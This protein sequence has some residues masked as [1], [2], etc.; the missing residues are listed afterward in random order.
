MTDQNEQQPLKS[1][2]ERI[3][4]CYINCSYINATLQRCLDI[5]ERDSILDEI[6]S[7][8]LAARTLVSIDLNSYLY[9][10]VRVNLNF[11]DFDINEK[12]NSRMNDFNSKID[13]NLYDIIHKA[14]RATYFIKADYTALISD[15]DAWLHSKYEEYDRNSNGIWRRLTQNLGHS[16]EEIIFLLSDMYN[17][18]GLVDITGESLFPEL[19]YVEPESDDNNSALAN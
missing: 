9:N 15:Y 7:R 8:R 13:D 5:V 6:S 18:L 3:G 11:K 2:I 14:V 19:E 16:I 4:D 12:Y 10:D 1:Q 17:Y